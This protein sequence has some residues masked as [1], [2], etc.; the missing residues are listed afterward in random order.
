MIASEEKGF[1]YLVSS[2]GVPGVR[3]EITTDINE[4]VDEIRKYTNIPDAVGFGIKTIEQARKMT[5]K[6]DGVIVGSAIV[7]IIEKYGD[8][9]NK[10]AYDYCYGIT[11]EINKL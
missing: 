10:P 5:E 6:T 4:I 2:L 3:D 7:S 9:A 11:S 1:I 8:N